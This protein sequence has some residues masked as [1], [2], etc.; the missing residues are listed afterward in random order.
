ME[1]QKITIRPLS[2]DLCEDW[3]HFFDKTAFEDHQ[4]WA[5]CYCLEGHLKH[6]THEEWTNPEE[7][8]EKAIELIHAGQMQGYLACLD[9]TV[10][11]WCNTNDRKN[12]P[13]LTDMFQDIGYLP[14][15]DADA[16]VK[17]IYC[18]LVAPKYRRRG[19]AQSLLNRICEDAA[20]GGYH[21]IEVYPFSDETF[22][23]PY[24]GTCKMYQ[25]NGFT[26]VAT[27]N[28]VKIMRKDLS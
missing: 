17:A 9:N 16:R 13:Y 8:R 14:E 15:E 28:Y 7:R 2:P 5:F 12:Y 27:L 24:H 21:C 1:E 22:E 23:F 19:V 26:E 20:K 11:G 25:R 10:I 3:L 18:F 6:E 4:D